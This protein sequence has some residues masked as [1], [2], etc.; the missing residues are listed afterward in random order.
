MSFNVSKC[1]V[2][3]LGQSNH[4]LHYS[5]NGVTLVSVEDERDLGV[6]ISNS[7]KPSK[8]C[9]MAAARANRILGL[10]RRNLNC[11]GRKVVLN[12]YMQHVRPHLEY[13]ILVSIL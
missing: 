5:M 4:N 10:I 13:A 2:L 7:L 1:K 9:A 3:H 6:N 8:Q 12:L 11:L